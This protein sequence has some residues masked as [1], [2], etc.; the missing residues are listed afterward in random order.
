MRHVEN[1]ETIFFHSARARTRLK[2]SLYF[3]IEC[4]TATK[5]VFRKINHM[6]NC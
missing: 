1:K 4:V 6:F 3:R 5:Y 2:A